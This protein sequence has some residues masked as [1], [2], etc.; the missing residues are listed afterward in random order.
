[1]D[2]K[3]TNN[4]TYPEARKHVEKETY[5][6]IAKSG[7]S[8]CN[9]VCTCGEKSQAEGQRK[10]DQDGREESDQRQE[11]KD[12]ATGS[13]GAPVDELQR[14]LSEQMADDIIPSQIIGKG[15]TRSN[16][17]LGLHKPKKLKKKSSPKWQ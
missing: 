3:Y 2:Y 12:S 4:V 5:A 13:D 9:C 17:N 10:A 16:E 14:I 1:M 6:K 11:P 7:T 8:T 15:R